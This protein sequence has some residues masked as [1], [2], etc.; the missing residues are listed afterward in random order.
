M[1]TTAPT[2]SGWIL[3]PFL[4]L[5]VSG[6]GLRVSEMRHVPTEPGQ[7]VESLVVDS[8]GNLVAAVVNSNAGL[9][10]PLNLPASIK[11]SD[12]TGRTIFVRSLPKVPGLGYLKIAVDGNDDIY[13]LGYAVEESGFPFTAQLYTFPGMRPGVGSYVMKLR[14]VNGDIVYASLI[15]G[16]DTGALAVA[17]NGELLFSTT[18]FNSPVTPGAYTSP[19]VGDSRTQFLYLGRVSWNGPNVAPTSSAAFVEAR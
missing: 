3:F 1:Q 9:I 6:A 10:T 13:V 8:R 7:S 4:L 12:S 15:G 17:P 5:S 16:G 18:A 2:I 14:G 19:A 11:K